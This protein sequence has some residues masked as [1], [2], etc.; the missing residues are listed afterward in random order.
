MGCDQAAGQEGGRRR[1]GKPLVWMRFYSQLSCRC[2]VRL[3]ALCF[4]KKI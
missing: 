3:T 4:V 1:S 2:E